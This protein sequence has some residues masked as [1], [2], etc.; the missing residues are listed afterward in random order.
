MTFVFAFMPIRKREETLTDL[1]SMP[2][3]AQ[4]QEEANRKE[5]QLYEFSSTG[6]EVISLTRGGIC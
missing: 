1:S 6:P 3:S 4:V 5:S 2:C